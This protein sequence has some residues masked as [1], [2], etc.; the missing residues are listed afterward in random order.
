MA[1]WPSTLKTDESFVEEIRDGRQIDQTAD[2]LA[3]VRK[4]HADRRGF[5]VNFP[6]LTSTQKST[7]DTFYGTNVTGSF[8]FTNPID[9][10]TYT[11]AFSAAPMYRKANGGRFYPCSVKLVQTA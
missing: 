3:R 8:Y 7:L 9:G 1:S 10:A 2:G 6:A 11:V 4:L 5:T